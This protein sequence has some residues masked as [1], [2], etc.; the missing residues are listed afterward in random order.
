M[1]G[2]VES[3]IIQQCC[4]CK[5]Q[6]EWDYQGIVG[7]QAP[8]SRVD[9][10]RGVVVDPGYGSRYDNDRIYFKEAQSQGEKLVGGNICD[11]CISSNLENGV[12]KYSDEEEFS[13][14][15]KNE[16]VKRQIMYEIINKWRTS[17]VRKEVETWLMICNR[18]FHS[19]GRVFL[20]KDIRHTIAKVIWKRPYGHDPGQ[21]CNL[22]IP[23]SHG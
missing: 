20:Y 22:F 4:V 18:I 13:T 15:K 7:C 1:S 6:F 14:R 19:H 11:I 21:I 16:A 3:T 9:D 8:I 12:L 10:E 17:I 2:K 5:H 23:W